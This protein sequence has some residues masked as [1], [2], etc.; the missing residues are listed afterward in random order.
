MITHAEITKEVRDW[1]KEVLETEN[2]VC[3]YAKKTWE[4]NK[5]NIIISNNIYWKDLYKKATN[6]PNE[7]DVVIYCDFNVDLHVDIFNDRINLLNTFFTQHNLWFMGFHQEHQEKSVVE[8]DHFEP[9]FEDSYN[10]IF[11]QKL[12]KLNKASETLEKIGYYKD[13]EDE[14]FQGI[15]KRRSKS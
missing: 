13:W 14:D 6:F 11:M 7:Y 9:H 4:N 12:D 8:Q 15:L 2:P 10:M 1:S 5:A 3:P